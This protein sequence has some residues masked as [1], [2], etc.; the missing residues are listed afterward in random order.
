MA[1]TSDLLAEFR[2]AHDATMLLNCMVGLLI[3]PRE[4]L[5]RLVPDD[6]LF[7]PEDWGI[8]RSSILCIERGKGTDITDRSLRWLIIRLRNAVA[9]FHVL[10]VH[11][12]GKVKGFELWDKSG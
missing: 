8:P 12:A 7:S 10:P 2:G 9:H 3:V 4:R 1:R 5:L 11:N 6:P